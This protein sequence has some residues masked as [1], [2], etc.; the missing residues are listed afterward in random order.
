MAH[1]APTG[2]IKLL[3]GSTAAKMIRVRMVTYRQ[4]VR[5]SRMVERL[6]AYIYELVQENAGERLTR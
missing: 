5:A 3:V 2:V 1:G 6:C 4:K